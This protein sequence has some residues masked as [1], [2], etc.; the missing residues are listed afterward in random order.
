MPIYNKLVRDRIP[1]VIENTGKKFS[2]RVSG[3]EEYITEQKI[4][5]LKKLKSM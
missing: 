1:E 4:R 5:A 3:N 2:T